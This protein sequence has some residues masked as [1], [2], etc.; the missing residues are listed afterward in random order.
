MLAPAV[1]VIEHF[2]PEGTMV[3]TDLLARVCAEIEQRL[4]ELRPLLDEYERL[5]EAA[6]TLVSIEVAANDSPPTMAPEPRPAKPR[7]G[8]RGARGSAARAI[9]LASS[10]AEP[11]A[12]APEPIPRAPRAPR[13]LPGMPSLRTQPG[14]GALTSLSTAPAHS[15]PSPAQ[16]PPALPEPVVEE[17]EPEPKRKPAS[18]SEVRQ[19]IVA[20]LEHG[21]HTISEL[22]MV[23]AMSTTEIRAN[24]SKLAR[25]RKVTRVKRQGDGKSAFALPSSSA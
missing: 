23:T 21:S 16:A 9:E 12:Q 1:C 8:A 18:P 7:R 14:P 6:D 10:P 17:P 19:A 4:T 20:A 15:E 25:Q 13:I 5:L 24:L 11:F 2:E 22:V 3:E